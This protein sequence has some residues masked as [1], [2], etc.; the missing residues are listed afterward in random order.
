MKLANSSRL[1]IFV[2]NGV[3]SLCLD[4]QCLSFVLVRLSLIRKVIVERNAEG[5]G[6]VG[7]F[8]EPIAEGRVAGAKP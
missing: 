2:R 4:W 1:L 8:S 3:E 5:K 7:Q 6:W